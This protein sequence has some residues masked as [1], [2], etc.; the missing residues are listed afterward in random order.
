[1]DNGERDIELRY[2][3]HRDVVAESSGERAVV[4][5]ADATE[6]STL[7]PVAAIIWSLLPATRPAMLDHLAGLF[8]DV[9]PNTLT[10]DLDRFLSEM[11]QRGLIVSVDADR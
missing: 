8:L 2:E 10:D 3:P 11:I 5:H 6:I 7:N 1:M 9:D 4:M